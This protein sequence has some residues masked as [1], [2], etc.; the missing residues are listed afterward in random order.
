[1]PSSRFGRMDRWTNKGACWEVVFHPPNVLPFSDFY[2]TLPFYL[3]LSVLGGGGFAFIS[4]CIL[5]AMNGLWRSIKP[6]ALYGITFR[7]CR[8]YEARQRQHLFRPSVCLS[9][10]G[11]KKQNVPF[12]V[13]D[14]GKESRLSRSSWHQNELFI[15]NAGKYRHAFTIG[16]CINFHIFKILLP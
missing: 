15:V 11:S 13:A 6:E 7:L 9:F 14:S 4:V 8:I 3:T 1:M 10:D 5:M 16:I 12:I 2:L